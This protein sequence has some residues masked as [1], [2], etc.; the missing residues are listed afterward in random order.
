VLQLTTAQAPAEAT[1]IYTG[2]MF[3]DS[4]YLFNLIDSSR[5]TS[6]R[7]T[8]LGGLPE[9]LRSAAAESLEA[10]STGGLSWGVLEHESGLAALQPLLSQIDTSAQ[11]LLPLANELD[12]SLW[13][14][15]GRSVHRNGVRSRNSSS[16]SISSDGMQWSQSYLDDNELEAPSQQQQLVHYGSPRRQSVDTARPKVWSGSGHV[17][18]LVLV[19]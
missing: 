2:L 14:S 4:E 1:A 18:E 16:A 3:C 9:V 19:L 12:D 6:S 11:A 17:C 13:R 8:R 15:H 5:P 7:P 10:V